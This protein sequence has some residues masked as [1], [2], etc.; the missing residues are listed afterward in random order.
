M[1]GLRPSVL[2]AAS[3]CLCLSACDGGEEAKKEGVP[4]KTRNAAAEA[5]LGGSSVHDKAQKEDEERRKKAFAERKAKE[6]EEDQRV[7][8]IIDGIVGLPEEMPKD[9]DS[10]CHEVL[11]QYEEWTKKV[12]FD[13]PGAILEFYEVKGK[14]LGE[15]KKRCMKAGSIEAAACQA[16]VLA[17]CP[18][19]FKK[20]E[21]KLL[22]S[23]LE[24]Y[25]PDAL[26]NIEAVGVAE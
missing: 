18:E 26:K 12:N 24:K 13:D 9:L 8:G 7:Q 5:M 1:Y 22:G 10:A 3:L 6:A 17:D 11:V 2:F 20:H 21:T 14:I 15:R 4:D 23:C 19:D 16:K 25:A